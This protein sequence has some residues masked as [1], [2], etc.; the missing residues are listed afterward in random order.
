MVEIR[1]EREKTIITFEASS[2]TIA[3]IRVLYHRR[4][5]AVCIFL[6]G[7]E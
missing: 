5:E 3:Y 2:N 4:F 6:G 7:E 1:Y